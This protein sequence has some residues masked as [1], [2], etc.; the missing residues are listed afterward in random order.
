[1][2]SPSKPDLAGF[3]RGQLDFGFTLANIADNLESQSA[4]H[5]RRRKRKAAAIAVDVRRLTPLLESSDL[6][7]E[8]LTRCSELEERLSKAAAA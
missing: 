3:V 5:V 2:I 8:I 7:T 1:M 4:E 6:R